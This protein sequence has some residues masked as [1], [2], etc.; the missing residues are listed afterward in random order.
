MMLVELSAPVTVEMVVLAFY[1]P[2]LV[3]D[4]DGVWWW[5]A[6]VNADGSLHLVRNDL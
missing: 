6:G 2:V 5:L 3:K 1:T 4:T